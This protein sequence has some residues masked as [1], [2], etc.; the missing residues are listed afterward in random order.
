[1]SGL[2]PR[3][4]F[5]AR[6]ARAAGVPRWRL[7]GAAFQR[8]ITGVYVGADVAVTTATLT[9]AALL[10]APRG[11]V[12]S[13]HTAA[14]LWGAIAPHSPDVHLSLPDMRRMVTRGVRSHRPVTP[15]VA[16]V[17]RG[18]P[19]T[20]PE[21]TFLDL[22]AELELVDLVVLGDS[23]VHV[24]AATPG[25][26]RAAAAEHRG[27][28]ARLAREAAALVRAGAESAMESRVRLLLVLAGLPEPATQYRV[29][30]AHGSYRLDLAWPR[31]KVALEYD[32]R[33][34]VEREA[35]WARDLGR[36]ESLEADGWRFVVTIAG[37]VF[38]TPEATLR[39][40]VHA[41]AQG[42]LRT[43]VRSNRWRRHFPGRS[44]AA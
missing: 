28:G 19:V 23:L 13:H 29:R 31:A 41:L 36:R 8:L 10:V 38:A 42:G 43:Q 37:D 22:A 26:L 4:P 20:T 40:V 33:H 5:T 44:A 34:H 25:A 39:R 18:M 16:V 3:R 27:R 12:V 24:G 15:L 21:R 35:Q 32:G 9:E 17:R 1:M 11:A 6:A 14:A 2:D 30:T 7:E